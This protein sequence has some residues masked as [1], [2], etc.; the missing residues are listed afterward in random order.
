MAEKSS[1][2][3]QLLN[4][5]YKRGFS[6]PLV[7]E[8]ILAYSNKRTK[9]D[10]RFDFLTK[11]EL[12]EK[13]L[14][15]KN[16]GT[17]FE[18]RE[19]GDPINAKLIHNGN[20]CRNPIVCP[21]CADRVSKRR[22]SIWAPRIRKAVAR[23]PYVY[24]MVLTLEDGPD[25]G[26]QLKALSKAR[27]RFRLMGQRRKKGYSHGEAR[28][29]KAA[30]VNTEIIFSDNGNVHIHSHLLIFCDSPV[31]YGIYDSGLKRDLEKKYGEGKIPPEELFK[32]A[33][34]YTLFKG[35]LIPTS[36]VSREWITATEGNGINISFS[37]LT[38]N[39]YDEK[40]FFKGKYVSNY[41]DW[42]VIN[43]VECLKY[44]SKLSI[45]KVEEKTGKKITP[46]QYIDLLLKKGSA[47]LFNTLGAFR[48]QDDSLYFDEKE[49]ERLEY[50]ENLKKSEYTIHSAQS[51]G[52]GEYAISGPL[53]GPIF[54]DSDPPG[55]R[56]RFRLKCMGEVMGS[57]I[58]DRFHALRFRELF[59]P[60]IDGF[61]LRLEAHLNRL[62]EAMRGTIKE[63]WRE[64]LECLSAKRYA[65]PACFT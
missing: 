32:I 42:L 58:R 51:S 11:N 56:K 52:A 23:F 55:D 44:N 35:K 46:Q 61:E 6:L 43:S 28:K 4:V 49:N 54:S 3:A 27:R 38:K 5:R 47:K 2:A 59:H 33:K 29:I 1:L 41:Q 53:P 13:L 8:A 15:I 30:T 31:D 63:I 21:V 19:Y 26:T 7:Q 36:K 64:S 12:Y 34:E 16:C 24:M 57:Y 50:V 40:P 20:F 25:I 48:K 18:I 10:M 39:I 9:H 65:V 22:R 37:P 60:E 14:K 45:E 17:L 62:H